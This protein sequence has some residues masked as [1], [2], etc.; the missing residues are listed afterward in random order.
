MI[1][2]I[3]IGLGVWLFFIAWLLHDTYPKLEKL[4]IDLGNVGFWLI[5]IGLILLFF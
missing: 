5:V 1:E 2:N 3:L 4:L